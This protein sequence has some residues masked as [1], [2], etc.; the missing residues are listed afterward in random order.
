MYHY[1]FTVYFLNISTLSHDDGAA[2]HKN[3]K[4]SSNN[5]ARIMHTI[6]EIGYVGRCEV[7]VDHKAMVHDG[8]RPHWPLPYSAPIFV[9]SLM[10]WNRSP[11]VLVASSYFFPISRY[12]I[13]AVAPPTSFTWSNLMLFK[14]SKDADDGGLGLHN[15]VTVNNFSCMW[16]RRTKTFYLAILSCH[17]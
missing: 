14:Y 2:S 9:D 1:T 4:R 5:S 6:R 15:D 3:D 17:W 13:T 7:A 8:Q 16:V 12:D 10:E 11:F